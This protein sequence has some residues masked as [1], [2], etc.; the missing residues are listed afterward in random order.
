MASREVER[1]RRKKK[2]LLQRKRAHLNASPT[3]LI[4]CEGKNTEPSYFNQLK[5]ASATI[6]AIGEGYNTSSLIKRAEDLTALKSYDEV[7]CVFDKDDFPLDDF[8][9]TIV[10]AEIKKINPVYSNQAFEY[11][12]LLHFNDHQGGALHRNDYNRMLNDALEPYKVTYEGNGCKII[13]PD[14]FNLLFSKDPKTGKNR[15]EQA[16]E[17]AERIYGQYD[18][19]SPALEESSTTV[20]KLMKHLKEYSRY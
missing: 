17:R 18:H 16:I 6:E 5:V 4:V 3:I 8:N 9:N 14:I 19:Q 10:T 15:N 12:I 1:K 7:W 2:H 11:W 13:T 20:F